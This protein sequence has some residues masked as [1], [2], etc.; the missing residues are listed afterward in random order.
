[1]GTRIFW[2]GR[3]GRALIF[4]E[5]YY[6][7]A[8]RRILGL[9]VPAGSPYAGAPAGIDPNAEH[10]PLGKVV[11]AA[12]MRLFGDDPWGW[13]LPS[14]LAGV[15]VIV[16]IYLLVRSTGHEEWTAVYAAGIASLDNLLFVHSRIDTLDVLFLAPL[17]VA[18]VLVVRRHHA[19]AGVACGVA[20]LVKV[21]AVFGLVALL[22]VVLVAPGAGRL[23][24][25][26]KWAGLL[27]GVSVVVMLLG[28]WALDVRFTTF[29]NPFA[30]LHH[31]NSY[32]FDLSRNGGPVNSES[33][34]WQWLSN[35]VQIPYLRVDTN[36]LVNGTVSTTQ[37]TVFFRGA[38]NP[39]LPAVA[40]IGL[41]YA[42]WR[43][44][45]LRDPLACWTVVWA[46]GFFLPFLGLAVF[47]HRIS[48]LYYALPLVPSFTIGATLLLWHEGL[49][50]VARWGFAGAMLLGF[51]AYFPFRSFLQ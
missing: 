49:P 14:V 48:Y 47:S 37:P 12:S 33:D 38:F 43:W 39:A 26:L 6:V 11:V 1:M 13:R 29:D 3:P 5:A 27:G 19:W 10:P 28:L 21:P 9:T 44:W 40:L 18:A 2:L 36:V 30:H 41:F 31:I 25:R 20:L 46:L 4:D 22:V 8:A 15:V 50:R 23:V 51:V 32:G 34:P 45:R 17:M 7:N 42:G 24:D 16:A 35:D